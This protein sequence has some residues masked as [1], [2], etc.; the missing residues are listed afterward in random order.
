MKITFKSMFLLLMCGLFDAVTGEV[1]TFP[2]ME[3][4]SV[5]LHT[6]LT[7]IKTVDRIVWTFADEASTDL[8]V[9][10][11]KNNISYVEGRFR[12]KLHISDP[13]VGD[14]TVKNMR[15]KHSGIYKANIVR[16]TGT[17][18]KTFRVLVSESP[19]VLDAGTCEMK[20][21]LKVGNSVTL[22]TD[23]QTHGD[24]LI[25]WRFGDEG[26][27]LAKYDKED[28]KS[29]IYDDERLSGRLKL[30]DQTGS[31]TI[32]NFRFS[33]YGLY[34]LKISSNS[35]NTLF[36]TFSVY[37]SG[38]SSEDSD[39]LAIS[40]ITLL[41]VAAAA[42]IIYCCRRYSIAKDMFPHLRDP[43]TLCTGVTDIQADDEILW[44]FG[45]EDNRIVRITG[46]INEPSYHYFPNGRFR[47][48][49][50]M[51]NKTGDLTIRSTTTEHNGVYQVEIYRSGKT[52][53]KEFRVTTSDAARSRGNEAANVNMPAE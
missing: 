50:E 36:K 34:K 6:D 48:R 1:K 42:L 32:S 52:T 4:D 13:K 23:V 51:N 53:Y 5:T 44:R 46:G 30:D 16:T 26:V 33:D 41:F 2:V 8:L 9:E 38:S 7:D 18:Y 24:D 19:R 22:H 39:T 37:V 31:L 10:M 11:R 17:T 49:L 21:V 3:G 47:E 14:L 20:S 15:I 12:D 35:K 28:N 29:S 43:V 40:I 27:L 25:V 45:P